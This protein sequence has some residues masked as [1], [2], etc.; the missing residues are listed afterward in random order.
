MLRYRGA[1]LAGTTQKGT[2][3]CWRAN[4][5]R[6]KLEN[7]EPNDAGLRNSCAAEADPV[8]PDGGM[9]KNPADRLRCGE[10]N[11]TQRFVIWKRICQCEDFRLCQSAISFG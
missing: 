8:C 10:E 1:G 11:V 3:H 6:A 9:A 7:C 4:T 2:A 5:E